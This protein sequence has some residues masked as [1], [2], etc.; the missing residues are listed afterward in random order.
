MNTLSDYDTLKYFLV[1]KDRMQ[2]VVIAQNPQDLNTAII[3]T[4]NT[5]DAI[6][7]SR[8]IGDHEGGRPRRQLP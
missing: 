2:Q 6:W 1:L 7:L 3:C 4:D 8:T 5:D